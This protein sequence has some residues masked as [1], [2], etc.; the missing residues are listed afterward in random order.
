MIVYVD[1]AYIPYGRMIMCHMIADTEEELHEMARKIGMKR[2]WFQTG[3]VWH[4]DV[5]LNKRAKAVLYGAVE[6]STKELIAL[7]KG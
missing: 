2:E 3:S 1:D 4:Y 5:S 7:T 6:V